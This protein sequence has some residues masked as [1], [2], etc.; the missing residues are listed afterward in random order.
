MKQLLST[1]LLC[2]TALCGHAQTVIDTVQY[3]IH[4][5]AKLQTTKEHYWVKHDDEHCLDIGRQA[6]HYYSRWREG[7]QVIID[8]MRANGASAMEAVMESRRIG[9]PTSYFYFDI[10]KNY[11][12]AGSCT[13]TLNLFKDFRYDEVMQMPEWEPLV[14]DTIIEGYNCQPA[15]TTFRGKTWRVWY[16]PDIPISDGPLKLYGLPGLI[17]KAEDTDHEFAFSCIGIKKHVGQ[18]MVI[19]SKKYVKTSPTELQALQILEKKD[20]EAFTKQIGT[21][22]LMEMDGTPAK[23]PSSTTCLWEYYETK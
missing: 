23:F 9:Y 12:S 11:P 6:S 19:R 5:A 13:V 14:G 21:K 8:S 7:N 10:F 4:Y 2:L 18:P 15:T 1:T 3:R 20:I 22:M 16:T 17:L